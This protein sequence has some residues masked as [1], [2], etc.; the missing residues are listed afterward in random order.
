MGYD[1]DGVKGG[2]SSGAFRAAPWHGLGASVNSKGEIVGMKV[3]ITDDIRTGR[4]LLIAAG[5]NWQV[6]KR[7]LADLGV[8]LEGAS[9][10]AVI[11]R[12]T[13]DPTKRRLLGVHSDRYGEIQNDI[14]GQYVDAIMQHRGDA[15]PVS[16]VEL[17]GGKVIFVVVEFRDLVKVVRRDGNEKDRMTRYMGIYTSH[18]GSHPLAV[19]YMN[20]LWVC[21]NT[22]APMNANTGFVIRHTRNGS[23]IAAAA[24]QSLEQMLTS[25]DTFD[26][27]IDR[28][29]ATEANK[30]MLTRAVIPTVIGERPKD[31]GRSQTMWDTAFDAIVGEWNDFTRGETAFDAVMAVQGYE[32]HRSTVRNNSRDVST[33][34]KILTDAWPLTQK[35]RKVFANA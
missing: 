11:T 20:Q 18:D 5:L 19:K 24:A 29:L 35:A 22:F 4:D 2:V 31:T 6:E 10:I 27:E 34:R 14:V 12:P 8:D 16:A 13:A 15:F 9:D 26:Q 33:I 32:Q 25:F 23:Q 28:L 30:Q 17:W 7:T 21:Q 1:K 3:P